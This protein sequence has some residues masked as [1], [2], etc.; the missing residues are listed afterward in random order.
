MHTDT[1]R[2]RVDELL[3]ELRHEAPTTRRVL[4]RIPETQLEWRPHEKSYSMGQLAMHVASLPAAIVQLSAQ[5]PFDL[6]A[7]HPPR[8]G[9][10][11]V[12]QVLRTFDESLAHATGLLEAMDDAT[13]ALPWRAVQGERDVVSITRGALLRTILLNHWYHHRGQLLVYLRL[14]GAKVPGV[15]GTSADE[16]PAFA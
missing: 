2:S 10:D 7:Q 11:S 13:L 5:S 3:D 12:A 14:T 4:E 8:P 16:A 1:T 9:A 6:A 15:Y